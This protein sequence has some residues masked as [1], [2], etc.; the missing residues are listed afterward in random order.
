MTASHPDIVTVTAT[1][2]ALPGES[3][4][5]V[6][7]SATAAQAKAA[8]V[9]AGS[10]EGNRLS[11]SDTLEEISGNWPRNVSFDENDEITA[12]INGVEL[13]FKNPIPYGPS[14]AK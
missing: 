13:T 4:F 7:Q 12:V 11:L 10:E 1:A 5:R 9:T 14:S 6:I 2:D 3:T 8:G